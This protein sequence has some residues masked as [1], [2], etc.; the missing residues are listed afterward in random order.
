[1][2]RLAPHLLF[3]VEADG[4]GIIF[5]P[6]DGQ[7]FMLNRTSALICRCLEKGTEKADILAAIAAYADNV[8]ETV[9]VE[10]ETFLDSLREH[11][12]LA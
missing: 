5:D 8:P 6:N 4:T 2:I 3:R 10:V 11:G 12:Y 9:E 1:M 7:T